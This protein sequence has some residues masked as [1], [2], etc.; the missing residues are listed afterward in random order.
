MKKADIIA[1]VAGQAGMSTSATE[2]A[3]D[4]VLDA[5]SEALAKEEVVRIAGYGRFATK[6]R[7][8]QTGCNP[9]T[10]ESVSIPASKAPSFK[11]GKALGDAVNAGRAS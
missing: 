5:I 6:D 1:R 9:R 4:A 2:G 11:A 7:R 3:L 8:A 10:G